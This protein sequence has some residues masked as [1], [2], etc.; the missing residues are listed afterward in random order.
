[1]TNS[2]RR[3]TESFRLAIRNYLKI[4]DVS[5][6]TLAEQVGV[7][8]VTFSRLLNGKTTYIKKTNYQ[9]ICGIIKITEEELKK[10]EDSLIKKSLGFEKLLILSPEKYELMKEET[11]D[12]L[13]RGHTTKNGVVN[14]RECICIEKKTS[15]ENGDDVMMRKGDT[16]YFGKI[17]T[18]KVF[19]VNNG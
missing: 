17:Q 3:V 8:P 4:N 5:G 15:I 9:A 12:F 7:C 16:H 11:E 2:K 19:V 14:G 13:Y 6:C 10:I 18:I 1:M